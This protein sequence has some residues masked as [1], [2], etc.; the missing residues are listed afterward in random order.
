[1]AIVDEKPS[2]Y[3]DPRW[4]E[5][6]RVNCAVSIHTVVSYSSAASF[7]LSLIYIMAFLG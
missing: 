1:M 6:R 4:V 7:S 5:K 2:E 3:E